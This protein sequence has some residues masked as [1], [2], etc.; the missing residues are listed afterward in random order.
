MS[1]RPRSNG[2]VEYICRTGSH[3][4]GSCVHPTI[5]TNTLDEAVWSRALSILTDPAV[6]TEELAKRRG[7]DPAQEEL[8]TIDATLARLERQQRVTAQAIASMEDAD[9]AAPLT[10][11]L[12]HLAI[13]RRTLL[14]EREQIVA[15]S[16]A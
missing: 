7:Q 14:A 4:L 8:A 3:T 5:V 2:K 16:A 9:A 13:Q 11:Q 6:I 15:R 12:Q 1:T 10:A